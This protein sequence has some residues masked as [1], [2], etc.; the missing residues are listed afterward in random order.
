MLLEYVPL[1]QV[2]RDLYSIPRG[3]SRFRAY[4]HT[5]IDPH[6]RD[7]RLP[8]VTMNPMGKEH[9]ARLIDELLRMD[10]EAVARQA[11]ERAAHVER[12]VTGSFRVALVVV[13]DVGGG[14]TNRHT[15]DYTN[16]FGTRPLLSR[17]WLTATVWT[18]DPP[19][20]ARV[21]EEAATVVHRAAYLLAH[22]E[23]QSLGEMLAQEG[24]AM[25]RAG[26]R[27][28]ALDG[29]ELAYTRQVLQPLLARRDRPTVMA[30]LYGDRAAQ[31]LGYAPQGLG[32]WAGL[33]LALHQAR[34]EAHAGKG[35]PTAAHG[36]TGSRAGAAAP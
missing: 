5:M 10:A 23:A 27:Q 1:L 25:A 35:S 32:D 8:L 16:R 20:R 34:A 18:A 14:W 9:V 7:L 3:G 17:G 4:L 15:N 36:T 24:Y 29:A 21:R 12:A 13:D 6:T 30:C 31:S 28:P 11:V 19:S 2:Q 33:A 22:G 26:C